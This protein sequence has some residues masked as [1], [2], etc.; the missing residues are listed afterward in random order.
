MIAYHIGLSQT[1]LIY[2]SFTSYVE[3]SFSTHP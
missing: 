2:Y 3:T 1:S